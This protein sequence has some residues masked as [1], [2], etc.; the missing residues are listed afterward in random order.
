MKLEY[1]GDS[2]MKLAHIAIAAALIAPAGTAAAQSQSDARCILVAN[3]FSKNSK[4][5][6]SAKAAEAASYFYLGRVSEG[7]SAAQLK[8]LFEAAS[9]GLTNENAG[10]TM[11]ACVKP[12]Q[13]RITMLQSISQSS[14]AAQPA[15]PT[16]KKPE[17]R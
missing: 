4:D 12:I 8:A 1:L 2:D 7:M 17:G 3:A 13:A 16:Q 6:N 14:Q 15:S 5:A 11:E 10:S 9:K